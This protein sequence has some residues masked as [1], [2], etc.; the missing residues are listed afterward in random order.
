MKIEKTQKVLIKETR[1]FR[2]H[3]FSSKRK[4]KFH[5]SFLFPIYVPR[6]FYEKIDYY[7][8]LDLFTD[9]IEL[10]DIVGYEPRPIYEYDNSNPF[11][12]K[13]M[14]LK[15]W[16]FDSMEDAESFVDSAEIIFALHG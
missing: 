4:R 5:V 11:R 13:N 9:A 10:F 8:S 7:R 15:Y 6:H 14:H 16:I 12:K 1:K 2:I 3:K